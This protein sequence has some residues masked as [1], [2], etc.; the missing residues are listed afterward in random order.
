MTRCRTPNRFNGP[1][2]LLAMALICSSSFMLMGIHALAAFT[3][4]FV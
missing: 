2:A 1:A 4:R 3:N